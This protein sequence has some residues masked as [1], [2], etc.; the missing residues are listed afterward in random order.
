MMNLCTCDII[1]SHLFYISMIV[2]IN[3][4]D[5]MK[6]MASQKYTLILTFSEHKTNCNSIGTTLRTG[7]QMLLTFGPLVKC[8]SFEN[9][10][11]FIHQLTG[12]DLMP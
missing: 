1:H 6:Y 12:N 3:S 11:V 8:K 10:Y 7:G 2:L 5:T 9:Q 4:R